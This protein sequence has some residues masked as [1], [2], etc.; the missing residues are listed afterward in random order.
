LS[1]VELVFLLKNRKEFL[2]TEA[3]HAFV[4]LKCRVT[5][6]VVTRVE[7]TRHSCIDQ[8][9]EQGI[10]VGELDMRSHIKVLG[11]AG[12]GRNSAYLESGGD[13]PRT[14]IRLPN[15]IKK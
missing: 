6:G 2:K 5:G 15:T 3:S 7:V 10:A 4:D 8:D 9:Y 12:L 14:I 11:N 13:L 1:F